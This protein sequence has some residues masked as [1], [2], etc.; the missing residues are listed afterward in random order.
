[1]K[2]DEKKEE[3]IFCKIVKKEIPSAE[4]YED[5]LVKAFLDINP[6]TYGH[7][8]LITKD[9]FPLMTDVPDEVVSH[10]FKVAKRLMKNIK[11]AYKAD[12]VTLAVVGIDVCHFHIHLIPRKRS[13]GIP[14]FWPTGEYEEGE[15]EREAERIRSH[16]SKDLKV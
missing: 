3:C 9:H 11:K 12:F 2:R 7:T 6:V 13:D 14:I 15:M 16:I 5:E 8:L 1:M 4:V 10:A